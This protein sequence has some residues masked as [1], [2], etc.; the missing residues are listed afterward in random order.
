[1]LL[2]WNTS[3]VAFFIPGRPQLWLAAIALSF[4][5]SFTQRI[6]NKDMHMIRV[7]QLARR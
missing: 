6:L 7:P 2:I 5:I 4:A 1:M 3:A